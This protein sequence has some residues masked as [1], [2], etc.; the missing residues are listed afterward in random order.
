M[1]LQNLKNKQLIDC[2]E[3]LPDNTH[4]L[5]LT[6][7]VTYGVSSDSSDNDVCGF[8]IPPKEDLF[9]WLQGEIPGFGEPFSRFETW[10][11]HQVIDTGAEKQYDFAVYSIVKF[12]QL[13]MENNPNVIDTL[14]VPN[15]AILHCSSIGQMIRDSR[16]MFL[17]KGCWVRFKGYAY[18]QLHKMATKVPVG[19]RKETIEKYGFDV[20]FAYHIVRLLNEVE[21]ILVE[22]D[23][24]LQRNREQLKAIRRGEWSQE[25]IIQYFN[26]KEKQ[27]EEI[28][29]KSQLPAL[30]DVVG[31]K[32]LLVQCLEKHFG[33]LEKAVHIPGRQ[34]EALRKIAQICQE[35]LI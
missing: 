21:Q 6:G 10:Q 29:L 31:I 1:I 18:Q 15:N 3:W 30:P 35:N 22:G 34:E 12:F 5:V 33:N 14:F 4:Y 2:P 13:C 11:Q 24:D 19:K 26:D 16:K 9:P 28:Y 20:K 17:H 23:L 32:A 25:Q 8:V 7:S 27:L